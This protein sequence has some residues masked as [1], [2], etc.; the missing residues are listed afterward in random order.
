MAHDG[1][2]ICPA[3]SWSTVVLKDAFLANR[4][5]ELYSKKRPNSSAVLFPWAVR[6]FLGDFLS[7]PGINDA[8]QAGSNMLDLSPTVRSPKKL[9]IMVLLSRLEELLNRHKPTEA[10]AALVEEVAAWMD[11]C[12]HL[13]K[14][15]RKCNDIYDEILAKRNLERKYVNER[16]QMIARVTESGPSGGLGN[17]APSPPHSAEVEPVEMVGGRQPA[18]APPSVPHRKVTSFGEA[19]A[20]PAAKRRQETH[21]QQ[22]QH[23]GAEV[24]APHAPPQPSQSYAIAEDPVSATID[25]LRKV[26]NDLERMEETI[27][28][29]EESISHFQAALM[30]FSRV[31]F[32][33]GLALI[34]LSGVSGDG[35]GIL[36]AFLPLVLV[37]VTGHWIALYPETTKMM[38]LSVV[39]F[40]TFLLYTLYTVLRWTI[41]DNDPAAPLNRQVLW[42]TLAFDALILVVT[43]YVHSILSIRQRV[44]LR[45]GNI[46][47]PL[48]A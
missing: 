20:A 19:P 45:Q 42:F 21:P 35:Y 7:P 12:R 33:V 27:D 43:K 44:L 13:S 30:T 48:K 31:L 29:E 38:P 3:Y 47:Y 10:D 37:S 32:V 17:D 39:C 1:L 22:P 9:V 4:L 26:N 25:R 40:I 8:G 2:R 15:E 41:Y 46:R 18:G 6:T 24:S 36:I 28:R 11:R 23:R 16:V 14:D 34:L 5:E